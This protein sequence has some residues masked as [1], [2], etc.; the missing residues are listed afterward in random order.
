[1]AKRDVIQ[2]LLSGILLALSFPNP[3]SVL[4]ADVY[5]G[6]LAWVALAPL[7]VS[8]HGKTPRQGLQLGWITGFVSFIGM[9]YWVILA[10]HGYGGIPVGLSLMILVVLA[11]YLGLYVGVFS[12][13]LCMIQ[14][15]TAWALWM[16]APPLWVALEYL[17]SVLLTGFPWENLGYSQ[18][19]ALPVIQIAEATGVYGV[20]FLV[21]W[22]NALISAGILEVRK[23]GKMPFRYPILTAVAL[24]SVLAYGAIRLSQENGRTLNEEPIK[25]AIVQGNIDQGVKWEAAY[26]E[27]TTEIYKTLTHEV[28]QGQPD[29]VIWPETAVPFFFP[30]DQPLSSVVETIPIRTG[31]YLLFGSPFYLK[32]NEQIRYLN[33]AYLLTPEGDIVDRYDKIHL[34]PFG[35][36][37]PLSRFIPFI[38]PLVENVGDFV[39]GDDT[40]GVVVFP[41]PKGRFGVLICYEIIF[42]DLNRNLIRRGADF[43]V[44]ITN[45]AWFGRTSAPFQHFSMAAFRAIEN[46]AY[47][48]RAANTGI[49]GIIASTG[50]ILAETG[51]FSRQ[52]MT[53]EL[54][55]RGPDTPYM[56]FG[57]VFAYACIGWAVLLIVGSSVGTP[58]R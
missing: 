7:W 53:G 29:L 22:V 25:I 36:Y 34:V 44:T 2:S 21:V 27:E 30:L 15:R 14:R 39:S 26:Q 10:M 54:F 52:T 3:L 9:L 48:A 5:F 33:S 13:L 35:E 11:L 31:V 43:L 1:M 24:G 19:L 6:G 16:V 28:A 4:K 17:R 18:Y 40:R 32:R 20:T 12:A 37:V 23:T 8:L 42:P 50:E 58:R 55:F 51:L 57:D 49:S 56:R 41:I 38:R 46:R 45:D 47:V